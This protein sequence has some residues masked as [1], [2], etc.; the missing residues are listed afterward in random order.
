MRFKRVRYSLYISSR[1]IFRNAIATSIL[2][3]NHVRN[4]DAS[5]FTY[6]VVCQYDVV[7]YV[8]LYNKRRRRGR[9]RK[10]QGSTCEK[11]KTLLSVD[12]RILDKYQWCSSMSAAFNC[13]FIR[14]VCKISLSYNYLP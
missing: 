11:T 2:I 14:I 9:R 8:L 1:I 6:L 5:L 13:N 4:S 3:F 12:I 10:G 7:K